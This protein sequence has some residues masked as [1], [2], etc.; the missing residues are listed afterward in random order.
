MVIVDAE[1]RV[2]HAVAGLSPRWPDMLTDTLLFATGKLTAERFEQALNPTPT[3]APA[4]A[5]VR[6]ERIAQL[7]R[8]LARRGLDDLAVEKFTEALK[9]DPHHLAAHL[10]LGDLLLKRHRLPDAEAHFRAV[11]AE[12]PASVPAALGLAFVQSQ[13]G[14]DELIQAERRVRDL[15]AANP[16]QARAHFLLGLICEQR[17]QTEDAAASF[18][19]AAQLLLERTE[20][21]AE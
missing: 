12:Q 11:L 10:D 15:L 9:L 5:D 21:E 6:A 8:Q 7:G 18:K 20:T 1:G 19:K 2:V 4:S 14:G 3:T 13:R 17:R 16:S